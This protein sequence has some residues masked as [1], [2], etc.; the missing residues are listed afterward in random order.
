MDGQGLSAVE[1]PRGMDRRGFLRLLVAGGTAAAA[2]ACSSSNGTISK[3]IRETDRRTSAG[4][5]PKSA[6]RAPA[7]A[8]FTAEIIASPR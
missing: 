6:S 2:W 1:G 3:L 4:L 7:S 5:A 8:T